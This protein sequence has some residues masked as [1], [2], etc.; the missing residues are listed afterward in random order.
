MNQR[1][2][3]LILLCAV[4]LVASAGARASESSGAALRNGRVVASV[5]VDRGDG[6]GDSDLFV[7]GLRNQAPRNL[8]D[9]AFGQ[10]TPSW[11]PDGRSIAFSSYVSGIQ[12][13]RADGSG[14]RTIV[15]P[16][17]R[18]TNFYPV[19]PS[20]SPD[21]TRLVYSELEADDNNNFISS[22][23]QTVRL[24]G[25]GRRTLAEFDHGAFGPDWSPDGKEIVFFACPSRDLVVRPDTDCN[26]HT[27]RRDGK[28]L[29]SF[30]EYIQPWDVYPAWTADGRIMFVSYRS[31]RPVST[32]GRCPGIYRMNRDGSG[33]EVVAP[34]GDW[35]GDGL[36]DYYRSV[37]PGQDPFKA[38][39]VVDTGAISPDETS[40]WLWNLRTGDRRQVFGDGI[41]PGF[42]WQP[43]CNVKG[44]GGDDVLTGTPGRDLICG[45]GGD[46]VI[47]GL[48]GDDVIF[49]HAGNDRIVGG[50][51]RDIVVGNVGRDICDVD[52]RDFSRVC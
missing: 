21:G 22:S 28:R 47:K 34:G 43:L 33:V 37:K 40:L 2:V 15:F 36:V 17:Y 45:L 11:S 5:Y 23:L 16:R 3:L 10:F 7:F 30:T 35:T 51:G 1:R 19:W 6:V 14:Q 25:T 18:E 12:V 42:D 4:G 13:M 49:G 31:C 50:A 46:D 26:L 32:D 44:S 39:V 24:D 20:W 8:T 41:A 9:R 29:R 27:V 52:A 38:L 48:G